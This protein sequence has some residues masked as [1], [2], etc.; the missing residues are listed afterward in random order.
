[1]IGARR[2]TS[3]RRSPT[4]TAWIYRI[5]RACGR[6]ALWTARGLTAY[7]ATDVAGAEAYATRLITDDDLIVAVAGELA[8]PVRCVAVVLQTDPSQQSG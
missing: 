2:S 7:D 8:A 1:M 6:V 3:P 5:S 4:S